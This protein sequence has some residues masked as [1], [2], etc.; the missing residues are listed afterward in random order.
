MGSE[1]L[2]NLPLNFRDY[3]LEVIS[4]AVSPAYKGDGTITE[5]EPLMQFITTHSNNTCNLLLRRISRK[6]ESFS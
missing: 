6:R 5:E 1:P 2:T 3:E 4:S